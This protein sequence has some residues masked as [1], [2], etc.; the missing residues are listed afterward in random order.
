MR[1]SMPACFTRRQEPRIRLAP[2]SSLPILQPASLAIPKA[3]DY[4]TV[5]YQPSR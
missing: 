2:D 4:L 3:V 1:V 5:F